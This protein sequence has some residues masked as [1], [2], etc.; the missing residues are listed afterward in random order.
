MINSRTDDRALRK[1]GRLGSIDSDQSGDRSST[2]VRQTR[3]AVRSVYDAGRGYLIAFDP[4]LERRSISVN[5]TS[6][7]RLKGSGVPDGV[8]FSVNGSRR[9]G[10]G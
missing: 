8:R 1:E 4:R 9:S 5:C 2:N 7:M 10:E 6:S 3:R